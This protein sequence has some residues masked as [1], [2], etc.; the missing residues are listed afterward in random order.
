VL[1]CPLRCVEVDGEVP[2]PVLGSNVIS[3]GSLAPDDPVLCGLYLVFV[4]SGLGIDVRGR[5][6]G[7]C[8][9]T[10]GLGEPIQERKEI[11]GR[12]ESGTG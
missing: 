8:G 5:R 7:E 4:V 10:K 1:V 6:G 11:D 2:E 3:K 12:K 9:S